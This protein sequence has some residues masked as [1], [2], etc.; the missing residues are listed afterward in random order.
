M[1]D[2]STLGVDDKRGTRFEVTTVLCVAVLPALYTSVVYLISPEIREEDFAYFAN[3]AS[4]IGFALYWLSATLLVVYLLW[5]RGDSFARMGFTF[6]FAT[7]PLSLAVCAA[8][9]VAQTGAH[10]LLSG[11]GGDMFAEELAKTAALFK[12]QDARLGLWSLLPIV[13]APLFEETVVRAYLQTRLVA[14][15]WGAA[16]AALTTALIQAA[17][18]L[19]QGPDCAVLAFPLFLVLALYY[20]RFRGATVVILAHFWWDLMPWI[21]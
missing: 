13:V 8:A 6:G 20:A 11:L 7:I 17:Y 16:S 3:P 9:Y 18:H 15:G 14:L 4:Q 5:Q 21:A 12:E 2:N 10:I 1:S 19:Y